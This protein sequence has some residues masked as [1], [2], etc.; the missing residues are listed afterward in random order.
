M[1]KTE[2]EEGP[3]AY[4]TQGHNKGRKTSQTKCINY[5]PCAQQIFILAEKHQVEHSVS[6]LD[7]F[8]S[9][10]P[11]SHKILSPGVLPNSH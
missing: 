5:D 10:F 4:K 8:Q 2:G 9:H 6:P 3:E 1:F 11:E 7:A